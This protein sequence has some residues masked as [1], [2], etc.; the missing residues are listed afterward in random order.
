MNEDYDVIIVGAGNGGL[1][2]AGDLSANCF[3]TLNLEK[4][5]LPGGSATS[6]KRG[7]FEFESALHELCM[8]GTAEN[9][10][11]V[12]KALDEFGTDI[13]WVIEQNTFRTI[14][15]SEHIDASFP[16]GREN[17]INKMEEVCPG[18]RHSVTR[19]FEL[20]DYIN[21]VLA[22]MDGPD[23]NPKDLI[24]KYSD[25]FRLAGH[26]LNEVEKALGMDE[27]TRNI[28]NTYWSY[29]GGD[30]DT[31][32]F[33]NFIMMLNGYVTYG[34]AMPRNRSHELSMALDKAI[35]DNGGE[36]WYNSPVDKILVDDNNKAY[37]VVT[38]GKEIHA[39]YI[40]SNV[41]PDFVYG[42]MIDSD[43]VPKKAKKLTNSR[44]LALQLFTV[45]L[46]LDATLDEIGGLDAYS[47][48]IAPCSNTRKQFEMGRNTRQYWGYNIVN[49]L[50]KVIPD[51]T[52]E[53]TC[54]LFMTTAFS[55]NGWD[56]LKPWEYDNAKTD[57]ADAMIKDAEEV[58]G[59][60]IFN[61]IEEIEIASPVTF[62]RYLGTPEGTPYGYQITPTD[63]LTLRKVISATENYIGNLYFAGAATDQ[64]DGYSTTYNSGINA[65]KQIIEKEKQKGEKVK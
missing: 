32:D 10:G 7:R 28:F 1:A 53:G 39:K 3:K 33:L 34:A 52:P 5:N 6:F 24:T 22:F 9:P 58:L 42:K 19:C 20:C 30:A 26:T 46:G 61:H 18:S 56:D 55:G 51:C 43:K 31:V 44:E 48:F 37:G 47:N 4:H 16:C 50:N 65:A 12:R 11:P 25:F 35:R 57:V 63:G 13:D 38:D 23:F 59:L 2:A 36:I 40:I 60:D 8:V 15:P 41:Y 27:R 62:A 17:F 49:S 64:G 14:I 54:Q 29:Q 21:K 45:Y